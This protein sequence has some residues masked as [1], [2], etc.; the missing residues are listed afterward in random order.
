MNAN[1]SIPKPKLTDFCEAKGIRR[2]A[3]FGSALRADFGPESDIDVLVEFVP[4]RIPGLLGM[5]DMEIEL[6]QL[7]GGRKV[8][9]R[10]PE[11][12]SRYFRQEVL[13]TAEVQ[14]AKE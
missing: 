10:T 2:L 7:L 13:D 5:A 6:S 3:I 11:D 9:L 1:I 12:L 4:D 14:Y 8:D